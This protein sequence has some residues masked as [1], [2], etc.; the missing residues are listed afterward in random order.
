MDGIYGEGEVTRLR[1]DIIW[2]PFQYLCLHSNSPFP[3]PDF[4]QQLTLE[5]CVCVYVYVYV[6][7]VQL[8]RSHLILPFLSLQCHSSEIQCL[9]SVFL[10]HY[11]AVDVDLDLDLTSKEKPNGKEKRERK[12]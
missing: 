3:T 6:Y 1:N 11:M 10:M 7:G 4:H 2:F 9:F 12:P 5:A 8:T